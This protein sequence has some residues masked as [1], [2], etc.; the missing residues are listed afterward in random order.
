MMERNLVPLDQAAQIRVVGDDA[1]DVAPAARP[2]ASGTA[3]SCRQWSSFDTAI[4]TRNALRRVFDLAMS[5]RRRLASVANCARR[6]SM[7]DELR[8][9]PP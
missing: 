6:F 4:S 2:I 5:S 1:H 8:T 7:R 9:P 3:G